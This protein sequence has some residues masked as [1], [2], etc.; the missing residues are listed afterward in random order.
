MKDLK[1]RTAL[2]TGASGGLGTHIARRLAREGMNVVI[3]GR[4]EDALA[5]VAGEL[6]ELGV[7]ARAVPADLSDLSQIDPLI[8][9]S[10]A[11]FG[12]ID[13]LVNNAGVEIASAFTSY[14]REELTSMVDVNLTAPLLLAHRLVPGMLARERGHVVF[15]SSVVGKLG[16]AYEGPYTATKAALIGLTQALRSEYLNASVGFSVICPG[17]I[18]GDGMYQRMVEEGVKSEP[19][20]GRDD[21][22]KVTDKVV[23]AIRRDQPEVVETGAPIRPILALNQLTPRFVERLVPRFGLTELFRRLAVSRG[24]TASAGRIG[25]VLRRSNTW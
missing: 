23:Q 3:S 10:E 16:L 19:P 21:N 5:A 24:R 2:V 17:F 12:P 4:R 22:Q 15:I 7:K 11:V 18:A 1:G 8:E 20:A 6:C 13:L 9:R 14:T 25:P